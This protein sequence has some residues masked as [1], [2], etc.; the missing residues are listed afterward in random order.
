MAVLGLC[1]SAGLSLVVIS[2]G[3]SLVVVLWLPAVEA[4]GLG[5][6]GCG[7]WA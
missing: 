7:I 3:C 6:S 2:G 5:F 4:L 1:C